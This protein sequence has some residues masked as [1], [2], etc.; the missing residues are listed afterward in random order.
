MDKAQVYKL[1]NSKQ[2]NKHWNPRKFKFRNYYAYIYLDKLENQD[3]NRLF[4]GKIQFTKIYLIKN[5]KFKQTK[6]HRGNRESYQGTNSQGNFTGE[7]KSSR[8]IKSQ[9]HKNSFWA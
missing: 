7:F 8:A 3:K 2:K 4:P 5:I 9:S 6:V 1:R